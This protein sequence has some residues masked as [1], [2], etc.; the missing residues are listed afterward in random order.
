[1]SS[2]SGLLS[3]ICLNVNLQHIDSCT[4]HRTS[5]IDNVRNSHH[6]RKQRLKIISPFLVHTQLNLKVMMYM[7][8]T[9]SYDVH[10]ED[11]KL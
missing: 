8:R 10:V 9:Q 6:P 4:V 5:F 2:I 3:V 1:M 11:S 7:L